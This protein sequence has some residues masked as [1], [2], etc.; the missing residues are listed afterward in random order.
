ML[1]ITGLH[2]ILLVLYKASTVGVRN[3]IRLS[4]NICF[5]ENQD[6]RDTNPNLSDYFESEQSNGKTTTRQKNE[7]LI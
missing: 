1:D 4:L 6:G 5:I 3:G 2:P 7:T